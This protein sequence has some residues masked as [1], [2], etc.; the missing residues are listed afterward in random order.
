MRLTLTGA[1]GNLGSVACRKLVESGHLVRATDRTY[2]TDVPVKLEIANLLNRESAYHLVEGAEAVVHLGN[3][4]GMRGN[5]GQTIFNE[6][7]A[8][9]MN[10]FEASR[11]CGVKKIV[12]AST[13]QVISGRRRADDADAGSKLPYLP[14]DGDVPPNPGNPYG[15]SKQASEV[16]LQYYARNWGMTCIALRFPLLAHP[17][18]ARHMRKDR[19][20]DP[21]W[22]PDEAFSYLHM[23]DAATL[24]DAILRAPLDGFG[25][26]FP[27]DPRPS[28]G[29]PI[30]DLIRKWFPN[31]S[32]RRPVE[33][34]A[35]LVDIS[36]I[37][38][39]TGW[40]PR[41]A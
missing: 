20:R 28:S 17:D 19:P 13:I 32:L 39:Q 37:T 27:V 31:V 22:N 26:Y 18:W 41:Q 11:Q 40:A 34:M 9:N 30:P 24:I 29:E 2:R 7:V 4:P 6:N 25:I 1:A 38:E 8:M 33:Q 15:L 35:S 23:V 36:R 10:V 5:D 12:F 14:L 16:M 3:H 21:W